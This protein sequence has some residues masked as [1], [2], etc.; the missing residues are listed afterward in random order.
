MLSQVKSDETGVTIVH[1]PSKVNAHVDR[2][3]VSSLTSADKGKMQEI[4]DAAVLQEM[5]EK[6]QAAAD[7]KKMKEEKRWKENERQE[8]GKK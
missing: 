4:T 5:K 1:M 6:E 3:N 8:R 7:A 2:H